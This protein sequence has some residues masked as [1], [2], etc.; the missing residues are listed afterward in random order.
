MLQNRTFVKSTRC[1]RRQA[2]AVQA[3]VGAGKSVLITGGNT[4]IGFETAK[5]LCGKG[6]DVTIACRD[7]TRAQNAVSALKAADP[8]AS[9]SYVIMDLAN[10]QS[11][12][13]AA[14][15]W[16]DSGKQ[17]DVLLNNAGVMACPYMTT[18]DGYEYQLGVNHLG[19][20]LWT[21]ELLPR[22]QENPNPVRVINV[23]SLAH[24]FGR[25]NFDDLQSQKSYDPWV[26]Y[27]QSKLANILFT[28]EMAR[29]LQPG[30]SGSSSSNNITVNA[31]H[32][33]VV[34]TELSRYLITDPDSMATKLLTFLATPF[35]LSPEQGAL[36]SIYLASSPEVEGVT[37]KYF[38]KC[39]PIPSTPLSY[40]L[41]VAV[42]FW[43]VSQELTA[44]KAKTA[45]AVVA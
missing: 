45:A 33:G 41:D 36:T 34:R 44:A 15:A 23:S 5:V 10:L 4:G 6:Y 26:A 28:Y 19:H 29:R 11:V 8:A 38:D 31:L 16:L 9:I 20:F 27:G 2:V 35:T 14:A 21:N 39:R 32:P 18:A 17:I 7:P 42:K 30:N 22:L 37:S 12:R 43:E 3:Q 40:D 25:I 1:S 24:T 13:D